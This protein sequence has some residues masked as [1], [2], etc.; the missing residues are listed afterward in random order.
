MRNIFVLLMAILP[1]SN[2]CTNQGG[3]TTTDTNAPSVKIVS[4]RGLGVS[5][6]KTQLTPYPSCGGGECFSFEFTIGIKLSGEMRSREIQIKAES[7]SDTKGCSRK[8]GKI[9]EAEKLYNEIANT[10]LSEVIV[11][12]INNEVVKVERLQSWQDD[13]YFRP[14]VVLWEK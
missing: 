2:S 9:P 8:A 7:Y 6:P 3:S 14:Q 1:C 13:G 11:T 12:L 4:P 5:K 10:S